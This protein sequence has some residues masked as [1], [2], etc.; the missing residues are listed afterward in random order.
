MGDLLFNPF[1]PFLIGIIGAICGFFFKKIPLYIASGLVA[2]WIGYHLLNPLQELA[3]LLTVVFIADGV[4]FLGP[5]WLVAAIVRW[6]QIA[7]YFIRVRNKVI[8]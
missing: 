5:M 2:A 1:F 6:R 4:I 3:F 8:R 7:H